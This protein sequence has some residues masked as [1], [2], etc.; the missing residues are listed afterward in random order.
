MRGRRTPH[1]RPTST[2]P[3]PGDRRKPTRSSRVT[4]AVGANRSTSLAAGPGRGGGGG[5]GGNT[6]GPAG[7]G[8]RGG[9]GG[10]G[11]PAATT[12]ADIRSTTNTAVSGGATLT[13]RVAAGI[14]APDPPRFSLAGGYLVVRLG[15]FVVAC[16]RARLAV[17]STYVDHK[18]STKRNSNQPPALS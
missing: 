13:T 9:G 15:Y 6:L 1:P 4:G 17:H 12:L 18:P 11:V 2:K 5:G 8:G 14:P 3:A 10:G 7:G 16:W